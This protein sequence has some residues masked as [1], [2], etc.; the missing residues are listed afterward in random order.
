MRVDVS[1]LYSR[2]RQEW[3]E[4]ALE[5]ERFDAHCQRL[6]DPSALELARKYAGDLYLSCICAS[7]DPEAMRLLERRGADTVR[8]A[9]SHVCH[10]A[11]FV[12][13][14]VQDFWE[15]LLSGDAPKIGEYA[16]RG[17]IHAWLRVGAIRHAIDELR[18]R[19]VYA[20]R[21]QTLDEALA[22]E[23]MGPETAALRRRYAPAFEGALSRAIADLSPRDRNVLRMQI[24]GNCS[25]DEIGQ[26][27]AVHRSTAARWLE[28]VRATV[29]ESVRMQL[30]GEHSALTPSEFRSIA[31]SL[32][33]GALG[34]F[35][36]S[37]FAPQEQR[38]S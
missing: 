23:S 16:G 24:Q 2:G 36:C 29:F 32:G 27:Y 21:Q 1:E 10:E 34:T 12:A 22:S 15:K 14:T 18:R 17:P 20:R 9:I 31:Q 5:F 25:I 38:Q 13:E 6:V 30:T 35:P 11:E 8:N 19:R 7:R 37:S 28:R 26:A 4:L 3:S 33:S